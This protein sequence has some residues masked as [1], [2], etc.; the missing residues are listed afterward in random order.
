[1][2]SNPLPLELNCEIYKFLKVEI[3]TKLISGLGKGI[4][5]M[6]HQKL[7]AQVYLSL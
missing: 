5:E 2:S 7:L 4:Y 1:M 6:F 3:Q